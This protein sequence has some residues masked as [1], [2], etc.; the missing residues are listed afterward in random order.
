MGHKIG[1]TALRKLLKKQ[2]YSL[3]SN[4]KTRDGEDHVDRDAQFCYINE[5][6]KEFIADG[7]PVISVDTKK[8][9]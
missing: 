8:K 9:T 5:K 6:A 4:R 1:V 2:G 3:Q 7:S